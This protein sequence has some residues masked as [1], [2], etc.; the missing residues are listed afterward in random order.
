M[1]LSHPIQMPLRLCWHLMAS[2]LVVVP[3]LSRNQNRYQP[4]NRKHFLLQLLNR[5]HQLLSSLLQQL[6]HLLHQPR[7]G[8]ASSFRIQN[9]YLL[10]KPKFLTLQQPHKPKLLPP[11][12]LRKLKLLHKPKLLTLQ[13]LFKPKL[14]HKPKLTKQ[15]RRKLKLPLPQRAYKLQ[16][17]LPQSPHLP[18]H[19]QRKQRENVFLL[20][21]WMNDRRCVNQNR[22]KPYGG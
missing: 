10:H 21:Y 22:T 7:A 19:T 4:K 12:Q 5:R 18:R 9:Q 20:G 14:R 11:Q 16:I 6:I 17:T 15:Q 1:L 3:S 8:G 13:P 2:I